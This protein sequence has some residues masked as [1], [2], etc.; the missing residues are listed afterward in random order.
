MWTHK[1]PSIPCPHMRVMECPKWVCIFLN[2]GVITT[3]TTTNN[4]VTMNCTLHCCVYI[5]LDMWVN[6]IRIAILNHKEQHRHKQA[7]GLPTFQKAYLKMCY[8]LIHKEALLDTVDTVDSHYLIP[9]QRLGFTSTRYAEIP[10]SSCFWNTTNHGNK[11][12]DKRITYISGLCG[13][14]TGQQQIII[15]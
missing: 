2:Y 12:K 5:L 1:G 8:W 9:L 7:K 11:L 10:V 13:L 4:S 3:L 6:N 14:P 15:K